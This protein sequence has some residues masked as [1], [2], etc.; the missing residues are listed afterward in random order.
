MASSPESGVVNPDG[1]VFSVENLYIVGAS[2][3]PTS[4]GV[5]PS[6]TVAACALKIATEFKQKVLSERRR[7]QVGQ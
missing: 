5:N 4:S 6:L 7:T 2:I 3:F 1:Q